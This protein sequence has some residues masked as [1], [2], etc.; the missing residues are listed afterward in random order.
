[1]LKQTQEKP[2]YWLAKLVILLLIKILYLVAR[3]RT[4]IL[5]KIIIMKLAINGI[6]LVPASVN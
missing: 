6:H 3:L 1:V 5:I 4:L 2:Q